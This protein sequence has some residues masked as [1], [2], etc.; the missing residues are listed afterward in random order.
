MAH[1]V[2]N[3]GGNAVK[4][5]SF[6]SLHGLQNGIPL[7]TGMPTG[8][9][10]GS[11]HPPHIRCGENFL[12]MNRKEHHMPTISYFE[13]RPHVTRGLLQ[14][15]TPNKEG[16]ATFTVLSAFNFTP[17]NQLVYVTSRLVEDPRI[18]LKYDP[19]T[20][21]AWQGVI[22]D[23]TVGTLLRDEFSGDCLLL[24]TEDGQEADVYLGTGTVWRIAREN[25][26]VSAQI[27]SW[28]E[29]ATVRV[30]QYQSQLELLTDSVDDIK[31]K[32]GIIGGAIRLLHLTKN[33]PGA[34]QVLVQFLGDEKLPLTAKMRAEI[35]NLLASW[36]DN[37]RFDFGEQSN[38]LNL[39]LLREHFKGAPAEEKKRKL[40]RANRDRQER[41]I[42]KGSSN[43]GGKQKQAGGKK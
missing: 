18:K 30:A 43:G 5:L 8:K 24:F 3:A 12:G 31:R 33:A 23:Q 11:Y 13:G 14:E 35:Y 21:R 15:I 36:N 1:F 22:A 40:D 29:T 25:G 10:D 9:N 27:L 32:H 26:I 38:V 34:R 20:I 19:K 42:M 2:V 39:T 28:T 17:L 16:A 37:A 7:V 41:A 6:D 4:C